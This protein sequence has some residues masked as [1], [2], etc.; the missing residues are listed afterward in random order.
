M[1]K[2]IV[3]QECKKDVQT[4]IDHLVFIWGEEKRKGMFIAPSTID[5]LNKEVKDINE[6]IQ[7][8]NVFMKYYDDLIGGVK[9]SSN[10]GSFESVYYNPATGKI[11]EALIV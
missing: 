5:I 11:R 7:F 3:D 2:L 1:N 4:L 10:I 6:N 8:T 9:I